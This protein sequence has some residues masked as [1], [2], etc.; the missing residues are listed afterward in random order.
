MNKNGV[1][2]IIKELEKS[3]LLLNQEEQMLVVDEIIKADKVFLAGVGRTGFVMKAF[4]N[5]LMHLGLKVYFVGEPTTPA[6]SKNDLLVIGS[7]SGKTESLI[8]MCKKAKDIGATVSTITIFPNAPIGTMS[9]IVVSIV[10][11][12]PKN[13]NNTS[14]ISFQPMGNAFEQMT[15]LVC[16]NMISILMD[17]LDKNVDEMF[18]L[19]ANL[20]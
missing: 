11:S 14:F 7:G 15:W 12:T 5:R 10:G 2:D 6:I 19:H 1:L 16:D 17:I 9:D 8:Y 4:S 3:A 18:Q 20:E 13:E